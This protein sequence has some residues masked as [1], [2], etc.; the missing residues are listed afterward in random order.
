M[1][2]KKDTVCT[3][4]LMACSCNHCCHENA[5]ISLFIVVDTY[6]AVHNISIQCCHENTTM[7]SL[8]TAVK[9]QNILKFL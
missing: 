5:T 9:L 2:N 4:I 3:T 7:G 8:C 1:Y 6:V